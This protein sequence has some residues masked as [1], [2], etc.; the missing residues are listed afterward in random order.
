MFYNYGNCLR[1]QQ[2]IEDAIIF[3]EEAIRLHPTYSKA[4]DNIGV[5]YDDGSEQGSKMAEKMYQKSIDANP[6]HPSAYSNLAS[7]Y[8][9]KERLQEAVKVLLSVQ[10]YDNPYYTATLKLAMIMKRRGFDRDAEQLY[11]HILLLFKNAESPIA[12]PYNHYGALLTEQKRYEEAIKVYEQ[13]IALE[14]LNPNPLVNLAWVKQTLG[15]SSG[16]SK[17]VRDAEEL[18]EKSLAIKPTSEAFMRLGSL[19]YQ[20]GETAEAKVEYEEARK[21]DPENHLIV[22][23]QSI[24]L[25]SAGETE[26]AIEILQVAVNKDKDCKLANL[27]ITLAKIYGPRKHQFMKAASVLENCHRKIG[28][29]K[30]EDEDAAEIKFQLGAMYHEIVRNN[31]NVANPTKNEEA[32]LAKAKQKTF[33]LLQEAIKL[34]PGDV[35]YRVLLAQVHLRSGNLKDGTHVLKTILKLKPDHE[36]ATILLNRVK[37]AESKTS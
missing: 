37:E 24:V 26:R 7:L 2:K 18:Y 22:L 36:V 29:N 30:H 17:M 11:Q 6:H 25:V 35:E 21:L 32:F 31:Q 19:K 23:E 13:A 20:R 8:A 33:E 16:S 12:E 34:K 14:P 3:Y 28:E 27:H 10:N 9:Q 5:L 1:N 4:F 15:I